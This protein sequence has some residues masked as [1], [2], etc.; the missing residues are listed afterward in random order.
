V[1][2]PAL[3]DETDR[4]ASTEYYNMGT[5]QLLARLGCVL[6]LPRLKCILLGEVPI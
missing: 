2:S 6:S 5:P 4:A 3:R 1:K